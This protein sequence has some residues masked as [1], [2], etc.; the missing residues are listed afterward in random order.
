[1]FPKENRFN[2]RLGDEFF[3][4][5]KRIY[6]PLFVLY[7]QQRE[8]KQV[9][10]TVIVPK[11][12]ASKATERSKIKRKMR[13]SLIPHLDKIASLNL[14]LYLKRSVSEEN[15]NDFEKEISYLVKKFKK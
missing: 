11:K 1:M 14:V 9:K 8:D 3:A 5:A 10:A 13:N 2:S 6:S 15:D 4:N 12:H 7:Y